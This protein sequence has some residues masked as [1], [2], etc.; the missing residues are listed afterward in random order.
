LRWVA[1]FQRNENPD[2][3]CYPSRP[4]PDLKVW[5]R[6]G[7]VNVIWITLGDFTLL[8]HFSKPFEALATTRFRRQIACDSP[9]MPEALH[10]SRGQSQPTAGPYPPY[11]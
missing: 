8:G 9:I 1:L 5:T 11:G 7:S 2:A 4:K 10:Q 3:G 6:S